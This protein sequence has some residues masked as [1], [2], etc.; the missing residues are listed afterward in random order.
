MLWIYS[1]GQIAPRSIVPILDP[2]E[3][4]IFCRVP[5]MCH[6]AQPANKQGDRHASIQHWAIGFAVEL[7]PGM[8]DFPA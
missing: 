7:Q 3:P 1:F 8:T 6:R 4:D 2:Q 5:R